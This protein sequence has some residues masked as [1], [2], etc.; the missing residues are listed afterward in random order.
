MISREMKEELVTKFHEGVEANLTANMG[1]VDLYRYCQNGD[2]DAVKQVCEKVRANICNAI[3][4]G[5][6]VPKAVMHVTCTGSGSD[7]RV[8]SLSLV[9]GIRDDK[10]FKFSIQLPVSENILD[11]LVMWFRA[12]YDKLV[13]EKFLEENI[14]GVNDLLAEISEMA[15]V[16]YKVRV[17]S[18]LN[19]EGRKISFISDE[20]ID[21]VVDMDNIFE[22]DDILVFQSPEGEFITEEKIAEAKKALADELGLIQTTVKL[23]ENHGGSLLKYLCGIGTQVKAITLIRKV[24]NKN[25]DRLRGTH[26]T[27]AYYENDGVYSVVCRRDG[28]YSVILKPIDVKTL[29]PVDIDV[30]A[31]IGA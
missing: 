27:F 6:E 10:K 7:I 11:R 28:Q 22:V 20:E 16:S 26:D 15:G 23:V 8:I 21:F 12:A 31:K 1:N 9:N 29:E 25:V 5:Y 14:E 19:C 30:L 4:E 17:V 18:P 13:M 24:N 2:S 3:P